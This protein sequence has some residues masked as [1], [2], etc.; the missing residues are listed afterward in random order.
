MARR[1][2]GEA[3]DGWVVIDKPAGISAAGV[4]NTVRRT[5]NAAKAGHAG[6][7]DPLATG[8]LPI[9]L[10]EA[11]KT[12][13][14]LVDTEKGY[15][16]TVRWGQ[17][18]ATDDAEGAIV[19]ESAVR[20]DKAAIEA[21]LPGFT[22]TITQVP[23]AF[24]AIK[25]EGRR[26][27]A[28][29][30]GGGET[31]VLE[32]RPVRID[33]ISLS[34]LIDADHA[35]FLVTCGK[36]TYMRALARDIARALGTVGHVASLRRTRVG[37]FTEEQAISLEDFAALGHSAAASG[38]LLEVE[39]VLDD[40]PALAL[41]NSEADRLRHGQPVPVIRTANRERIRDLADGT[42]LCAVQDGKL[43]A[44]TRLDGRMVHPVRVLN[45]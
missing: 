34:R 3:I 14:Y 4:V 45:H 33:A 37:P 8:V 1:R 10:G 19:E 17:A 32:P 25:V 5:L 30:R 7:L 44:Y 11:T 20:P 18:T 41:T 26:A 24:S 12:I 36:G 2:R 38:H 40:I 15:R 42:I 13:T 16:F 21:V 29:A 43:I 31:P 27:Y 6:T 28:I 22:G 23:P 35:E 9:A 39:T